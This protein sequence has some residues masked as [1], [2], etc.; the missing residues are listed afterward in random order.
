[1]MAVSRQANDTCSRKVSD[2]FGIY[3]MIKVH[4]K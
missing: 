1:M 4:V 3:N 2:T